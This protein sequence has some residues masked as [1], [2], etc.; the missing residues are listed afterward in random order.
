MKNDAKITTL[1]LQYR[2]ISTLRMIF[3]ISFDWL[4]IIALLTFFI[5][6]PGWLSFFLIFILV[7]ARQ[8]S[9][10]ILLHDA[11]HTLLNNNRNI[12]DSVAT[13]FLAA[14]F[15]VIFS[16]SRSIHM[17]HHQNLG[18]GANDPDFPLYCINEP[19]P[20]NT[21]SKLIFHFLR[22]IFWSKLQR[23]F[24]N[25]HTP[26]VRV[27]PATN[28]R[29]I[30]AL[31]SC[32]AFIFTAFATAGFWHAYFYLWLLPLLIV[33][34][35]LNDARIFCEHSNLQDNQHKS[36]G[37]LISYLSS[38]LERFFFSPHHMNYHAE[39]HFFPFIPHYHLP[40]IRKIL[41]S[42]PAYQDQIQ[43]RPSYCSHLT[44]FIHS[45][46][47]ITATNIPDKESTNTI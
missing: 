18:T 32:Q 22:Q 44:N 46:S 4:Q 36:K 33:A 35:F 31:L 38:P 29:E 1:M 40:K 2:K 23:V 30:A 9:L 12:N 25:Q 24:L 42:L 15:G 34:T 39:H 16:K 37:L 11:Q 13:W 45:I 43:W 17:Q 8:Y 6:F 47:K 26:A 21:P 28:I 27:A 14:P 5:Y 10:L 19:E 7:G 41:S 3:E 20:K